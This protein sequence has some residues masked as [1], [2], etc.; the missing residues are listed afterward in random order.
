[1]FDLM[2]NVGVAWP[3]TRTI[4]SVHGVYSPIRRVRLHS[5]YPLL[6]GIP[7]GTEDW[8]YSNFLS[9]EPTNYSD[10]YDVIRIVH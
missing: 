5:R 2:R 9:K 4:I 6:K 3:M 7:P 10:Y 1:M 8:I